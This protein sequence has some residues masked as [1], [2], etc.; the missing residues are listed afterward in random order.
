MKQINIILI[1]VFAV[2]MTSNRL[3]SKTSLND[4]LDI[5]VITCIYDGFDGENF[6]FIRIKE[7]DAEEYLFFQK[8]LTEVLEKYN[9]SE[10]KFKGK[11]FEVTF[12]SEIETE[13]DEDGDEQEYDVFTITNLELLD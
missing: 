13:I 8:I 7:G 1:V 2:L 6:T 9:L 10:D 12:S 11:L 3:Q 4:C 5:K